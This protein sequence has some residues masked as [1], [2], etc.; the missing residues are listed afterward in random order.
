MS[1]YLESRE[2]PKKNPVLDIKFEVPVEEEGRSKLEKSTYVLLYVF[3]Y[4]YYSYVYTAR[5]L[6]VNSVCTESC[7]SFT[8]SLTYCCQTNLLLNISFETQVIHS[9]FQNVPETE[10]N[11]V[12]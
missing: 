5:D 11:A 7:E 3:M 9:I 1:K 4:M 10:K 8:F 2:R 6:R 12:A